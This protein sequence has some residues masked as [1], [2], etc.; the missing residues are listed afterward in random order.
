MEGNRELQKKK[1]QERKQQTHQEAEAYEYL[2]IGSTF[3]KYGKRG[4]PKVRHV[5]CHSTNLFWRDPK[6]SNLPDEKKKGQRCIPIKDISGYVLGR[7]TK[8]FERFKKVGKDN[9]SFTIKAKVRDLDLEAT[10]E[11][12][13]VLFLTQLDVILLK[14]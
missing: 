10:S 6:D 14:F 13:K 3:I 11:A 2:S 5:L 12:E 7:T 9:L 4:Q 1:T 8:N